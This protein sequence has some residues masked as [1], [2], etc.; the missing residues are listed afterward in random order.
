MFYLQFSFVRGEF[1]CKQTL[2]KYT[3]VGYFKR[4]KKTAMF[5]Q[6]FFIKIHK[7]NKIYIKPVRFSI[8]LYIYKSKWT[9]IDIKT[10]IVLV[11]LGS[12]IS[13]RNLVLTWNFHLCDVFVRQ[14]FVLNLPVWTAL[15]YSTTGIKK[16][17]E[18]VCNK[19]LILLKTNSLL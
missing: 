8:I 2:L 12:K 15:S 17:N 16:F 19:T 6:I 10:I 13:S 5:T 11:I 18:N 14:N 4:T 7:A 3:Y 1:A 9:G